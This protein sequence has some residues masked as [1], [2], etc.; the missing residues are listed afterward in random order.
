MTDSTEQ[1]AYLVTSGTYSDYQ[2]LRLFLDRAKAEE[3]ARRYE[4]EYREYTTVEGWDVTREVPGQVVWWRASWDRS[5]G[6]FEPLVRFPFWSD[7]DSWADRADPDV[8]YEGPGFRRLV[9]FSKDAERADQV[10]REKVAEIVAA[11]ETGDPS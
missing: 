5:T 3:F 9:V 10:L 2:V 6:A 8:V 7:A 4:A 11:A 1:K